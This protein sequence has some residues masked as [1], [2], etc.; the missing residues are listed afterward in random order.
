MLQ[1]AARETQQPCSLCC[2]KLPLSDFPHSRAIVLLFL[3]Y[4]VFSVQSVNLCKT[5][6]CSTPCLYP[7]SEV[8]VRFSSWCAYTH[9]LFLQLLREDGVTWTLTPRLCPLL[10]T[11]Q[12]TAS[13]EQQP[14]SGMLAQHFKKTFSLSNL[15][16]ALRVLTHLSH[17]GS[18]TGQKLAF[19]TSL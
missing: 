10:F 3:S 15:P 12:R 14:R 17:L 5:R 18:V 11:T 1:T 19:C 7:D 6:M 4:R 16:L 13:E 2:S 8:S 9:G